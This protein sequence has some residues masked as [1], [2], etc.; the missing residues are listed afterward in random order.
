[1]EFLSYMISGAGVEIS[2]EK[3]ETLKKIKLVDPLEDELRFLGFA[4][5]TGG[6]WGWGLLP[7]D[8]QVTAPGRTATRATNSAWR[9]AYRSCCTE[10]ANPP[11]R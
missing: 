5:F 7:A 2:D 9:Y 6:S 1:M 4:G 3:I 11:G 8:K 10:Q